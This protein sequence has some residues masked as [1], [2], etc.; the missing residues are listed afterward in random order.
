MRSTHRFN[1]YEY[2][3]AIVPGAVIVMSLLVIFNH[4]AGAN[5]TD[6]SLGTFA[7]FLLISYAT[8]HV[9]QIIGT[10][11]EAF[12]WRLLSGMPIDWVRSRPGT[13]L[14]AD[15]TLVLERRL[16]MVLDQPA[17][18]TIARLDGRSWYFL[19]RQVTSLV[20]AA[21]GSLRLDQL[22]G[23][24]NLSR[25]LSAA[26]FAT[27]MIMIVADPYTA[28]Q[29]DPNML[30]FAIMAFSFGV[31]ALFRMQRFGVQYALELF[32]QFLLLPVAPAAIAAPEPERVFV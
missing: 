4:P 19:T 1:F 13:L 20:Q 17:D 22:Q 23:N 8:G 10:V 2:A 24:Y 30:F 18:F 25:G 31:L 3:E 32:A 7:L 9:V 12:W 16:Q 27:S 29:D 5:L 14:P 28:I 6:W 26:L 21:G 11:L 15:Q